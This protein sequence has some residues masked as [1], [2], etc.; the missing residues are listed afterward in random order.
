MHLAYLEAQ[1]NL[2]QNPTRVCSIPPQT[3]AHQHSTLLL[4][5][6]ALKK[7]I[8]TLSQSCSI[9]H[10][11]FSYSVHFWTFK[12][13]GEEGGDKWLVFVLAFFWCWSWNPG[14]PV[15]WAGGL[16]WATA[17]A[18]EGMSSALFR[19][20]FTPI[21]FYCHKE[22][23]TWWFIFNQ[24]FCKAQRDKDYTKSPSK[25]QKA[26]FESASQRW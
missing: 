15:C 22:T 7:Q 4:S 19:L 14:L 3:E 16:P 1:N 26:H 10:R 12:K 6:E 8:V 24:C 25:Q 5:L 20:Y 17:R 23:K 11:P 9:L 2:M 13:A 21:A 18:A